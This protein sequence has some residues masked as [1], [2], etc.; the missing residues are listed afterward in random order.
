MAKKPKKPALNAHDQALYN[1]IMENLRRDNNGYVLKNYSSAEMVEI[2][3]FKEEQEAGIG[4]DRNKNAHRVGM[5]TPVYQLFTS[6]GV[7]RERFVRTLQAE[8]DCLAPDFDAQLA[9]T[10]RTQITEAIRSRS[11]TC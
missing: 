5:V 1:R 7:E 2:A 8:L 6:Y 10:L 11:N 9:L 3:V 4:F